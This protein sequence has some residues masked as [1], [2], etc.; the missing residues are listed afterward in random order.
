MTSAGHLEQALLQGDEHSSSSLWTTQ[1]GK[2]RSSGRTT[3]R[4]LRRIH[5]TTFVTRRTA[6]VIASPLPTAAFLG[7][8]CFQAALRP[9]KRCT[10]NEIVAITSRR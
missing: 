3:K 2:A 6:I 8:G 7:Q 1:P 4:Y 10:T 5:L 9:L